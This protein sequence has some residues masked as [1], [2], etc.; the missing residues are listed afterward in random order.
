MGVHVCGPECVVSEEMRLMIITCL[1]YF[2]QSIFHI[3]G[4]KFDRFS[5]WKE[6][7]QFLPSS[8]LGNVAAVSNPY[9]HNISII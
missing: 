1:V 4:V 7:A 3:L 5:T 2:S 6:K 8:N 9:F